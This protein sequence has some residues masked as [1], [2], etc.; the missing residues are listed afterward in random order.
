M[1][2]DCYAEYACGHIE[3]DETLMDVGETSYCNTCNRPQVIVARLK[4]TQVL[5][6]L[7]DR[8]KEPSET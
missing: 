5:Q 2:E 3:L 4:R 7:P 1:R 6:V 8:D